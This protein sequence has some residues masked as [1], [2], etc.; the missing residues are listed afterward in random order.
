MDE[1]R[2][3]WEIDEVRKSIHKDFAVL[4]HRDLSADRR[5]AI[6]EHLRICNSTLKTLRQKLT[7][8]RT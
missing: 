7:P 2:L 4:A 8:E 5:K 1:K 6:S 3:L